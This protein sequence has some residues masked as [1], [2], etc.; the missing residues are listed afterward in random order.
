VVSLEV[1]GGGVLSFAVG[2][3]IARIGPLVGIVAAGLAAYWI[4]RR[5]ILGPTA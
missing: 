5:Y 2:T 4:Y 3:V 1:L